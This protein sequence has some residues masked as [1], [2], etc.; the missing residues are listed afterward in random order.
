MGEFTS[1]ITFWLSVSRPKKRQTLALTLGLA[2]STT[3]LE[4]PDNKSSDVV[5]PYLIRIQLRFRR[6]RTPCFLLFKHVVKSEH[7]QI[8]R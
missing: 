4:S 7:V 6:S 5:D 2:A 8:L 1:F 3:W